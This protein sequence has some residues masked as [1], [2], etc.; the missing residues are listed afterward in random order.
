MYEIINITTKAQ[1]GIF[2]SYAAA[3]NW[4]KAHGGMENFRIFPW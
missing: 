3:E 2:A 4:V 1:E